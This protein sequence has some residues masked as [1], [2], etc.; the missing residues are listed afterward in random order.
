[1]N[2]NEWFVD[3]FD[4][5][6]YHQ[7]YKTRD[8]D[9]AQH[10]IETLLDFLQLAPS[11]TV[12]DLA[13]GK[14]RHARTLANHELNVFGV[15]LSENSIQF[16]KKFEKENLHFA[17]QDMRE[18]LHQKFDAVF[19]LFT[20][21]GYFD[22]TEDN[23][24]VVDAVY[25]MLN[26]NGLFI[27]DFMNAH[28]VAKSLVPTEFKTI[29]DVGYSIK[30]EFTGVHIQKQIEIKDKEKSFVF[31][32]RV[33]YLIEKDFRTLLESNGFEVQQVFG[34]FNLDPFNQESSDR[35]ILIAKKT[36]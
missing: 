32:E 4:T 20:S 17:V 28:K 29:E 22:S 10:F 8:E 27:I 5:E 11:S 23:E 33:Q 12:L 18:P 15:D 31:T 34:N 3:W 36:K 9:E 30:R 1:M 25:S 6:Y 13:C 16:A 24:K 14:G 7:L 2:S 26:P 19:N 21:F 35:L